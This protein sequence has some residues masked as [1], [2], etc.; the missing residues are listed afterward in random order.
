MGGVRDSERLDSRLALL[1]REEAALRLRLGQALEVLREGGVFELGFS[2]LSAYV[3]ERCDR[4]VRWAEAARCLARRAEGLPVLRRAIASG[5]VSWS[6][7]EL[8]AR[9]AQAENEAQWLE[10]AEGRTVRQMRVLVAKAMAAGHCAGE[11]GLGFFGIEEPPERSADA[12]GSPAGDCTDEGAGSLDRVSHP[13]DDGPHDGRGASGSGGIEREIEGAAPTTR[14]EGGEG[15]GVLDEEGAE[16]GE[17]AC[18]LSCTVDREE[19]WLFEATRL[20]LDRMGVR[21]SQAQS[22][23]LLAEGQGTLLAALPE[24]ALDMDRLENG[25]R[26][27][28]RWERELARWRVEAE[29]LSENHFCGSLWTTRD[30]RFF[31]EPIDADPPRDEAQPDERRERCANHLAPA[32]R[33]AVALAAARGMVSLARLGGSALDARVREL[34]RAL[35]RH[36]LEVSRLALRFHRAGGWRCMKYATEAQY[37]RERLG[38]SISSLRGRRSLALRLEKLPRVAEALGA[39]EIGVEAALQVVRVATGRTQAAWVERARRRTVKHLR[40]EVVAALVAIRCSGE[41]DCVPPAD[42]EIDA[43]LELERAVVSGRACSAEAR[44]ANDTGGRAKVTRPAEVRL[45]EPASEERRA[46]WLMLS[47]LAGWLER[48]VQLSAGWP[49]E[50]LGSLQVSGGTEVVGE[51]PG[52]T[53]V[54]RA[55]RVAL[56][57]R[58]S[59]STYVWWRA[60][61]AQA[62]RWLPPD[63]SWLRFLCLSMWQAWRHLLGSSAAYSEIYERDCYRCGSPVCGRRDVTPHHLRFRSAGGSEAPANIRSLCTWCHLWGVH[64]GRIEA[65]GTVPLILWKF[66]VGSPCLVVH[67]RERRAA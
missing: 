41:V 64:G 8:V 37:A 6:M 16:E 9:V 46:W 48:G 61:E 39:G 59:R 52:A 22:E 26:A 57:L 12:H 13:G 24:G 65:T 33:S 38:W 45:A 20:L 44:V 30:R 36:E 11:N 67:G 43:F 35:A 32:P 54:G 40:E 34:S 58:M 50:G 47:R 10:V 17:G 23:A 21:G 53:G 42:E 15:D 7:A 63:M 55:G 66:G 14:V 56:R 19:L 28:Q 51:R 31:L 5:T 29:V 18:K 62:R 60:L 4:S 25:V 2:S 1:A 49:F 27:E 3:L